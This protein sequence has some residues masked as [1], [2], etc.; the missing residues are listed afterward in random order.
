M[1]RKLYE[2]LEK[3]GGNGEHVTRAY[4]SCRKRHRRCSGD[5]SQPCKECRAAGKVSTCAYPPKCRAGPRIGWVKDLQRESQN[6]KEIRQEL[7]VTRQELA[8]TRQ[9]L[10]VTRKELAVARQDLIDIREDLIHTHLHNR[11]LET[12]TDITHFWDD[13]K[14]PPEVHV[15]CDDFKGVY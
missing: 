7:T 12:K 15:W 11:H 9:E 13:E 5:G 1:K 10:A 4:S 2:K 6:A 14:R 8:V 3:D